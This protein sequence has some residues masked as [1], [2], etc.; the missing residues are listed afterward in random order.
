MVDNFPHA[1]NLTH[2][3]ADVEVVAGN[4]NHAFQSDSIWQAAYD[5]FT[6]IHTIFCTKSPTNLCFQLLRRSGADVD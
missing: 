3:A 1:F 6:D 4:S 5:E 2:R